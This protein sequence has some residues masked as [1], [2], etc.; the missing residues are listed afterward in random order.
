VNSTRDREVGAGYDYQWDV[1][2]LL[3][4]TCVL[5]PQRRVRGLDEDFDWLGPISRVH[6]EGDPV[7]GALE[8]LTFYGVSG[9]HLHLQI[10]EREGDGASRWKKRDE[11]LI[12]FMNRAAEHAG[13]PDRRFA[14]LSNGVYDRTLKKMLEDPKTLAAYRNAEVKK[15][16]SKRLD[17]V[18]PVARYERLGESVRL[19]RFLEATEPGPNGNPVSGVA[20][21][22][23]HRLYE[24]GARAPE[25]AYRR[26]YMWVK[27]LAIR[28]GNSPLSVDG[29]RREILALLGLKEADLARQRHVHSLLGLLSDPLRAKQGQFSL[30]DIR[31]GQLFTDEEELQRAEEVL[32]RHQKLLVLGHRAAGKT[33]FVGQ[34][35]VRASHAGAFPVLWDFENLG[36]DLPVQVSDYLA[37]VATVANVSGMRPLLVLENAH[38]NAR[39]FQMVLALISDFPGMAL[40]ASARGDGGLQRQLSEAQAQ[41]LASATFQL[42]QG[43]SPRG[44]RVLDWHL[45]R[46][47]GLSE[48]EVER[49]YASVNWSDY[50]GD[51]ILLDGVLKTYDWSTY[52][53]PAWAVHARL[54]E[55]I[56]PVQRES[57]RADDL[58]FI[59]AALG[60]SGLPV[61]YKAAARML[62]ASEDEF[63]RLVLRLSDDGMLVLE[64]GHSLARF[65]HQSIAQLFWELFRIERGSLARGARQAL[66]LE[67]V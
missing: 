66:H 64:E 2:V 18:Q 47:R 27:D 10:K 54:Q 39:T 59:L 15:H 57:S 28:K 52:S 17:Q 32:Q 16:F 37:A 19:R 50:V 38:L 12:E 20:Y 36:A 35:A 33:V 25:E 63:H 34:L 51:L 49:V 29:V 21:M 40:L 23:I 31:N 24:L 67:E 46:K 9:R 65:W 26:I 13:D 44:K 14:L 22:A 61:D 4:L 1:S 56:E 6:L 11:K 60:R 41:E 62:G 3:V 58:L 55:M 8:D 7:Q 53:L 30:S 48:S 5:T 42:D 45:T 43:T